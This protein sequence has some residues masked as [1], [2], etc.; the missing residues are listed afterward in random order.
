MSALSNRRAGMR[1]A[2][3]L[4]GL[5]F[6]R[7]V[8]TARADDLSLGN[9]RWH[10]QCDCGSE[11]VAQGGALTTGRQKSCGC[12]QRET[13][14]KHGMEG[15]LTYTTWAQMKARCLNPEHRSY[16]LYGG[17]GITVSESWLKFEN[18]FSDMGVKPK[19]K[20]LDRIDNDG[21]YE[22]GNCRWATLFEQN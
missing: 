19:G 15:S 12:L 2:K 11:T 3:N 9:P 8:V 22:S 20:S 21:N 1:K 14:T 13:A 16:A 6:N 5:R 17:R 10:C 7:L 18:F 4:V